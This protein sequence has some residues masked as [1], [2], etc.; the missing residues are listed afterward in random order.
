L[1]SA[2]GSLAEV[3]RLGINKKSAEVRAQAQVYTKEALAVVVRLMRGQNI[4]RGKMWADVLPQTQA[5]AAQEILNRG[6]AALRLL[7][8]HAGEQR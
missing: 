1:T 2:T 5:F 7:A 3:A 8:H 4:T 6:W